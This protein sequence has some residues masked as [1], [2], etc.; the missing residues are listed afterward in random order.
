M[1]SG[2]FVM[3][4]CVIGRVQ[5]VEARSCHVFPRHSHDSYGIGLIV[6]GAQRS[7]SGRGAVE[8]KRGNIITCNPGEVH[9]GRPVGDY[10]EWKIVYLAPSLVGAVV[11]DIRDGGSADFEFIN[12]VIDRPSQAQVFEAAYRA[13]TGQSPDAGYLQ[14][15][16][17]LLLAGL[18]RPAPPSSAL[19]PPGLAR[20]KARIDEDPAAPTTLAEL[21]REAGMSRFQVVRGFARLTGLTP[22]AYIVQ[23]RLEAARVMIAAGGTLV[24]AATGFADQS[25]FSR[26]FIRRYGVTPGAY[27]K[28]MR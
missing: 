10:R 13:L 12:P 17:I 4:R 8:A 1:E 26:T 5:A 6:N 7:W 20:A 27:A 21:A 19:T 25:H 15:R 24:E 2:S 28:A 22:H 18:L 14:E 23:R 3:R 9:D 11:A 16:L